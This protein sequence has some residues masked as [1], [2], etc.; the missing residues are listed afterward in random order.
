MADVEDDPKANEA[1]D[2][3]EIDLGSEP[4]PYAVLEEKY[5]SQMHQIFTQKIELP[6]ST[7]LD[8]INHQIDLS[9]HFQRRGIWKLDRRSR[10]IESIIM[11]VPIP[12]VFL[13]EDEYGKYVVLDGR[14]R[15]T[16]VSEFL[17]NNYALTDLRVWSELN[18]LRFNDLKKKSLDITLTR[19]FIPA[20]LILKESS[21]DVKY[22]VFD[23]LN[24]GGVIAEAMEIRNAVARGPC[25][26]MLHELSDNVTFRKLWEIPLA[27]E[28]REVLPV[29][30]RMEDLELVLRFIALLNP[31]DYDDYSG[32]FRDYLTHVLNEKNK[33]YK[34]DPSLRK[35][36][37]TLFDRA[38]TNAWKVFGADAFRKPAAQGKRGKKSAPLA[39]A[40]MHALRGYDPSKISDPVAARV[41][42]RIDDLCLKDATFKAAIGTGTNGRSATR[43]RLRAAADAVRDAMV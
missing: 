10:F 16:A 15:L 18:D 6:I 37:E 25:T 39:D 19:R 28:E 1:D 30:N 13:G 24:T 23:R 22:D 33:A 11:N 14:Q 21:A 20:V 5:R 31:K 27:H 2:D 40:V 35:A 29:Y 3:G 42:K 43:N 4:Q 34:A 41:K 38:V 32:T 8:M 12:P 9:P 7:I 36:D 17:A 26:D